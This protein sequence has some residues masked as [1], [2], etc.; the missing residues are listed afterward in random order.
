ML[1]RYILSGICLK[2]SI[3]S[4]LSFMEYMGSCDFSLSTY[5]NNDYENMRI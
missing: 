2:L 4:Q 5:F 1:L 3:F